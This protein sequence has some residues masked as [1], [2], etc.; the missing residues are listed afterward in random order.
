MLPR[1]LLFLF[2]SGLLWS[3]CRPSPAGNGNAPAAN[4][5]A[6]LSVAPLPPDA[7]KSR[8]QAIRFLENRARQDP[9][10]FIALNKLTGYYL[11]LQRETGN[12]QYLELAERAARNSLKAMPAA[13]NKAGLGAAANVAYASHRFEEARDLGQQLAQIEPDKGYPYQTIGDALL[14]LGDYDGAEKAFAKSE[15]LSGV[16]FGNEVRRARRA[17]LRGN[18]QAAAGNYAKALQL[19]QEAATSDAET[20]AWTH[21][22]L[23]ETAFAQGQYAAA[24]KRYQNSLQ[25]FPDYHRALGGLARARAAQGDTKQAVEIYEKL[26]KRLPDPVY[27]AALGDLYQLAGRPQEAA[28]QYALVEQIAKLNALNGALYNRQLALFYADHDL[29]TE[30]AYAAAA[31]EYETRRDIYGADALAWTALKAGKIAEAQTAAQ[32]ALRLNTKDAKLLYHAG[33]IARAAGDKASAQ[34]YLRQALGLS[35]QFDPLQA[36]LAQKALN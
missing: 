24:E 26:V 7:D 10:D 36:T 16:T 34:K 2:L 25:Q 23:G 29:Q 33:L 6:P 13:Q 28:A 32:N 17:A 5:N 14:E 35:P 22:Q 31:K 30:A 4:N 8:E 19:A 21:W 9:D 15:Q 1:T 20:I 18:W 27:I 12:A 3:G 11:Q